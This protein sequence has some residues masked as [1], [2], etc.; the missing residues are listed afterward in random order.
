[1]AE[2]WDELTDVIEETGWAAHISD[3][4]W[5]LRW[6]S[7]ELRLL[8]GDP[9]DE[10]LGIG[11]HVMDA[12]HLEAWR[13]SATE[14]S[15]RRVFELDLPKMIDG[16]PGGREALA[17]MLDESEL[18][19]LEGVEPEPVPTAW[20]SV[21]EFLQGDLPPARVRV[22]TV[23]LGSTEAPRGIVRFYGSALPARVL[24][25]VGR[26]DEEMF[27]RMARLLEPARREAAVLFA[28]LQASGAIARRLPT[29]AF[30]ELIRGLTTAFDGR[31]LEGKGIVGKH[32]GDG[33]TAFFTSEE[34]GSA[35]MAV[36]HAVEAARAVGELARD[37]GGRQ[38]EPIDPEDCVMN[39]GIHWGDRLFMGQVVTGGRIEVTAL[40]DE[41]NECA[42]IEQAASDGEIL[43]SKQAI[44][45]LSP[46]DAAALGLD[47]A[48]LTY[49][50][51]AERGKASEKAIRDAGGVA[52]TDVRPRG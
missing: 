28:D 7:P 36:R 35:S 3:A 2:S 40:G 24:A 25:L 34:H 10:E 43:A 50:T 46:D 31:I 13:G 16:T 15:A 12:G 22:L 38:S 48:Q 14:A 21:L 26:G 52:V 37:A 30:F 9:D 6:V 49:E 42:R 8:L 44:E 45:R 32:A 39:I 4:E 20:T 17:K 11:R 1:M 51:L 5:V 18:K 19:L 27:A 33:V 29:A 23:R 41:V 47:P